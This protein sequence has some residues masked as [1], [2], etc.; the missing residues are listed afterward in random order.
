MNR[1]AKTQR[2]SSRTQVCDRLKL[3]LRLVKLCRATF[4]VVSLRPYT[5]VAYSTNYFHDTWHILSDAHGARLLARLMWGLSFQRKPGTV[6]LIHGEHIKPT[7]F[8]AEP[9]DPILLFP[10]HLTSQ[11]KGAL[12][13]LRDRISRLGPPLCTIRWHTFSLDAAMTREKA[14]GP[15]DS[16]H[17]FHGNDWLWYEDSKPLFKSEQMFRRGGFVCYAAPSA[18]MR[19]QALTVAQMQPGK[20]GMDYHFIADNDTCHWADGE[21]QIF[22]DYHAR[23]TA[24][25]QARRE[26]LRRGNVPNDPQVLYDMIAAHRDEILRR[27]KAARH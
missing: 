22:D 1:D 3:H 13:T 19:Q 14:R 24:A 26:V 17:E 8:D 20:Y 15:Y 18:I 6:V 21:V 23:R 25:T 11:T 27:R 9:S 5:G 16:T 2:Y 10:A 12:R 7:P 4:R